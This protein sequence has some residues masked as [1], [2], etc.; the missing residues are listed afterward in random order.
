M[1]RSFF[2]FFFLGCACLRLFLSCDV[3]A[4]NT[5]L[6]IT[7]F[8]QGSILLCTIMTT[9]IYSSVATPYS[10]QCA[11]CLLF[12]FI[13][14]H[15]I[16]GLVF[17]FKSCIHVPRPRPAPPA[18]NPC[19]R[20]CSRVPAA[21]YRRDKSSAA[22]GIV[23]HTL[24]GRVRAWPGFTLV[25]V[26]RQSTSLGRHVLDGCSKYTRREP[27]RNRLYYALDKI[28]LPT[29]HSNQD[30]WQTN[31]CALLAVLLL[32]LLARPHNNLHHHPSVLAKLPSAQKLAVGRPVRLER[33][34]AAGHGT[35]RSSHVLVNGGQHV[36]AAVLVHRPDQRLDLVGLH[37]RPPLG[38][39]RQ[40]VDDELERVLVD[41][42]VVGVGDAGVP[43]GRRAV[44]EHAVQDGLVQQLVVFGVE[45]NLALPLELLGVHGL[46]VGEEVG[47]GARVV[48]PRARRGVD[49]LAGRRLAAC[50]SA[51][52][53]A[54][55]CARQGGQEVVHHAA[56][57]AED[58]NGHGRVSLE[59]DDEG[60]D[61]VLGPHFGL[62][63]AVC[64]SRQVT[65]VKERKDWDC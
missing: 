23:T 46:G 3:G 35:L 2:F 60:S 52:A 43:R 12:Y 22:R 59:D 55:A 62:C 41:Q 45:R 50:A 38:H 39:E 49:L 54:A 47:H 34:V 61:D 64:N 56:E 29:Q 42:H 28:K 48:A 30:I 7:S 8:F 15:F 6:F 13:L 44:E 58:G 32:L 31:K 18:P 9:T 65:E 1:S 11:S 19:V 4:G 33:L 53:A 51:A 20:I 36:R 25:Y 21:A 27:N 5:A 14:F 16:F 24:P 26:A 10:A 17:L 40:P 63:C 57:G 37:G